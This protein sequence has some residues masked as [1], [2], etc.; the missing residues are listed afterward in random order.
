M[1]VSPSFAASIA[2][3]IDGYASGTFSSR[4]MIGS[5]TAVIFMLEDMPNVRRVLPD[6]SPCQPTNLK[7]SSGTASTSTK[8]PYS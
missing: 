5:K 4:G 8:V 3:C 2:A 7:P 6:A 1:I